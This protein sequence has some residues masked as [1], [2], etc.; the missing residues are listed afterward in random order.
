[1]FYRYRAA[2]LVAALVLPSAPAADGARPGPVPDELRERLKLDPFYQKYADAGGLPVVGSAKVSDNALA[3]AAWIVR[4]MLAGRDDILRAMAGQNVRAAV[5]AA[6]EYTTDVPEHGKLQPK[7]FWDRRARGLGATPRAPAVSCGEENLLNFPRDPYPNENIFVHE[8]GHAIHGTGLNKTDP[9]FDR[10]LRAAYAAA[11]DRGLWAN[12]YAITNPAEYWAEGVQC[13]FDDNAPPDALH[14]SVRTRAQLREYDEGLAGLCRE[15]FGDNPW[16][17][18]KPRDRK[19]EDRAHLVGYDPAALPRFRWRD[20][21]T[22]DRPQA[23]V[24]TALG[25]FEVELDPKAAPEAVE[26]FLRTALDGG[27][28]SGRFTRASKGA[29]WAEP[30]PAWR[31]KWMADLGVKAVPSGTNKP[32]AGDIALVRDP[33]GAVGFA[34]IDGDAPDLGANEIVPFGRVTKGMDAIGKIRGAPAKDSA[35]DPP[36]DVRRVIRDR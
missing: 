26:N 27:Y 17:Y 34:V 11:R 24:Q 10:R 8:F 12:T 5:M 1:M 31:E 18:V 32:K 4:Q 3:E 35:F 28:H 36:V 29:L 14:N 25:D 16:R 7:L 15:V 2:A 19:P 33:A 30:N 9:T 23:T 6:T 21:P 13:W 22:G 20:E